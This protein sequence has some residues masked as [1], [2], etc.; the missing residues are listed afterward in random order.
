MRVYAEEQKARVTAIRDHLAV[1][2]ETTADDLNEAPDFAARGGVFKARALFGPG[3]PTLIE[4]LTDALAAGYHRRIDIIRRRQCQ[5]PRK[6]SN[7]AAAKPS[8]CRRSS[9]CRARK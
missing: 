9:V 7:M 2:V 6:S 1:N 8:G 3:L 4:E 5:R